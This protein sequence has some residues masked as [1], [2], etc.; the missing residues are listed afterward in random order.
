MLKRSIGKKR[1]LVPVVAL[2]LIAAITGTAF[3]SMPAS[4]YSNFSWSGQLGLN[5]VGSYDSNETRLIQRVLRSAVNP[6]VSID[7]IYGSQTKSK[8]EV[9]QDHFGLD[10]DGKVGNQTWGSF[11]SDLAWTRTDDPEW[12]SGRNM[13]YYSYNLPL[14]GENYYIRHYAD[15]AWYVQDTDDDWFHVN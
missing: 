5:M 8:V 13:W 7:G 14:D 12:S 1:F 2:L 3:A 15:G 11:Q 4:G 9:Y 10:A 6:A